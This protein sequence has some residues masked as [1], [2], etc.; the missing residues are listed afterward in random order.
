[1]QSTTPTQ[2]APTFEWEGKATLEWIGVDD[3]VVDSTY[4]RE[5]EP[6]KVARIV[7]DFDPDAFG[8]L[9]ISLREDGTKAVI[10]GS[11]RRAAVIEM[12]WNDQKVPANIH[13]GLS[14][15]DEARI[16]SIL[17]SNRTKPKVVD[18][19]RANVAAGQ[20][21][22]VAINQV[23]VKHGLVPTQQVKGDGIRAIGTCQRIFQGGSLEL[24][25][26]VLDTVIKAYGSRHSNN[27]DSDFLTPLAAIIQDNP[28]VDLPRLRKTVNGLGEAKAIVARGR[29]VSSVSGTRTLNEIAN[30]IIRK[31]NVGLRKGQLAEYNGTQTI[32]SLR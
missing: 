20:P 17:N 10:D 19:F 16:F 12:G 23:F 13:R 6:R 27:F 4:Q 24:L 29:S 14:V 28:E 3:L 31:Y 9:V 22:A 25:D 11:H 8:S 18:L 7:N 30:F 5:L 1:M 21:M 2:E 32:F 15:E 26:R